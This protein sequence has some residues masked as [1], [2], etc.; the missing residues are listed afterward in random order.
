MGGGPPALRT[1]GY[2]PQADKGW[3]AE[4]GRFWGALTAQG[5]QGDSVPRRFLFSTLFFAIKEKWRLYIS[6][7]SSITLHNISYGTDYKITQL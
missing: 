2:Q 6:P 3:Q 7:F 4:S 5:V 1:Q